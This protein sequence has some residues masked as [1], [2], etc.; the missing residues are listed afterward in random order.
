MEN[1]YL[2]PIFAIVANL[3]CLIPN[4][5]KDHPFHRL[6]F[7]FYITVAIFNLA[8]AILCVSTSESLSRGTWAYMMVPTWYAIPVLLVSMSS[9]ASGRGLFSK[10]TIITLILFLPALIILFAR[11]DTFLVGFRPTSFAPLSLHMS[12]WGN[13]MGA[14][15]QIVGICMSIYLLL[16]PVRWVSFFSRKFFFAAIGLW[17]LPMF[18][19]LAASA[20]VDLPPPHSIVDVILSVMFSIYFNRLSIGVSHALRLISNVLISLAMS[21]IVGILLWEFIDQFESAE[22]ILLFISSF[23]ACIFVSILNLSEISNSEQSTQSIELALQEFQLS[24]QEL[25]ICELLHEGHSRGFVQ[26]VLNVSEGTLRNHL[27]NIYAKVLPKTKSQSKDQ[28]QRLTVM[29]SKRLDRTVGKPARLAEK[30]NGGTD[31]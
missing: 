13:L 26:L 29:L 30:S 25:R 28:L 1:F 20:G 18:G 9:F 31:V 7:I 3:G 27:K 22:L 21:V 8:T 16:K 6:L 15:P 24:K 23:V 2:I 5:G 12:T 17:W 11:P 14:Y 10:S 19:N 4:L